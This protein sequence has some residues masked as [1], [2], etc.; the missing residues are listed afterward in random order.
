MILY[1]VI[2][3][4][5]P[6]SFKAAMEMDINEDL[7]GEYFARFHKDLYFYGF[8]DRYFN[9][10]IYTFWMAQG[11]LHGVFVFVVPLF[12][13]SDSILLEDGKTADH[14]SF[15]LTV[16][17][18][19]YLVFMVKALMGTRHHNLILIFINTC[20]VI[21]PFCFCLW[22]FNRMPE[23]ED[24]LAFD[25]LVR[26]PKFYLTAFFCFGTFYIVELFWQRVY[27]TCYPEA[28][29][30]I[31]KFAVRKQMLTQEELQEFYEMC[32]ENRNRYSKGYAFK[33]GRDPQIYAE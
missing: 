30:F 31:R 25:M 22:A 18:S 9:W 16:F 2:Y 33:Q 7:D 17:V 1:A 11:F 8:Y 10:R 32:K 21:L 14:W 27:Y 6:V 24:Y 12:A 28:K 19:L 20:L 4:T 15:G 23:S 13:F 26:S 29:E 3:S 5:F